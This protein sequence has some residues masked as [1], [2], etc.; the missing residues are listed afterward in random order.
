MPISEI[1]KQIGNAVPVPLA[2][3]LS[4]ES[5]EVLMNKFEE[6]TQ[7]ASKPDVNLVEEL[8]KADTKQR[9]T[10]IEEAEAPHKGTQYSRECGGSMKVIYIIDDTD[11]D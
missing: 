6:E 4:K 1:H 7:G 2:L 11:S 8:S 3:A 5:L 10:K 9:H